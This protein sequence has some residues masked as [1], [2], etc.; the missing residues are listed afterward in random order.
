MGGRVV[1]TCVTMLAQGGQ[2]VCDDAGPRLRRQ[3]VHHFSAAA[4]CAHFPLQYHTS[5]VTG[6]QFAPRSMML[7][8]AA[9]DGTLALWPQF[10]ASPEQQHPQ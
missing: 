2:D 3:P 7:A 4:A 9:R 10:Q 1:R 6:I 8:T 5:P